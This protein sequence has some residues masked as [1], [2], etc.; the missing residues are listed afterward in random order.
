MT[1]IEYFSYVSTRACAD[2]V[3]TVFLCV[4]DEFG[5]TVDDVRSFAEKSGWL[6]EVEDDAALLIAPVVPKG[7]KAVQPDA[8]RDIYLHDRNAFKAPSRVS[9]PGRNGTVWTWEPLIFLVGYR[10]GATY[11]GNLSIAHPAFAAASILVDGAPD[12]YSA[13]DEPS[14]HWFVPVPSKAYH[15]LCHEVPLAAWLFGSAAS[16]QRFIDYI[17]ATKSP[18]WALRV[19]GELSGDDPRIARKAMREFMSHVM[20]WKSAPDGILAWRGSR[21]EF[22]TDGRYR[23]ASV[24]VGGHAYHYAVYLPKGLGEK[25]VRGLPLVFSIHGR[26][27]PAWIFS[28]KNGWECLADETREFVVVLPDSPYDLWFPDRDGDVPEKIIEQV[29][30]QYGCDAERVYITGFSNGALFTCQEASTRPWLFAAASPWNGPEE[31]K[32][33]ADGFQSFVYDRGLLDSGYDIPFWYYVGDSDN[34]AALGDRESEIDFMT[35]A[36]GCSRDSEVVW[37][38]SEHYPSDEGYLQG[39]RLSTRAFANAGGSVRVGFTVMRDMP[40][41]A[42]PDEA[43]AAWNFMKRFRRPTGAKHVE[44]V[45]R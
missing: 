18:D 2:P 17:H 16:D 43:R 6:D 12:D 44:E 14:D 11:A 26:G 32:M 1:G 31:K 21:R 5:K 22:Y 45:A 41:G 8:V 27:E 13:A 7:W 38:S 37:D 29:V 36:N 42:I 30:D 20:R 4:P 34:K 23:H 39:D 9:M 25:D 3:K 35:A 24:D 33:V 28:E 40:H 15:A 19:S 10:E